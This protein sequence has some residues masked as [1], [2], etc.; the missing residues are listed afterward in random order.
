M[1]GHP[2]AHAAIWEGIPLQITWN[3]T[4]VELPHLDF[5][6]AHLEVRSETG[7]PLPISETGYRS[8]FLPRDAVEEY[9]GPV[10]YVTAWLGHEASKTEWQKYV[11]ER[12]QL[13]LF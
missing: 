2:E 1:M 6:T 5:A 10:E 13:S 3:P 11:Q 8:N 12:R 9:G 4:W 7:E